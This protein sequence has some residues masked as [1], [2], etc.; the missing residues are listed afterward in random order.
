MTKPASAEE[1]LEPR[2]WWGGRVTAVQVAWT[3]VAVALLA[4][5]GAEIIGERWHAGPWPLDLP[6]VVAATVP[7][8]FFP[9]RPV[10]AVATVAVAAAL[11]ALLFTTPQ[12]LAVMF[13]SLFAAGAAAR[14]APRRALAPLLALIS[15]MI[16]VAALRDPTE[17]SPYN[18][19]F[20]FGI[21]ATAAASG[22]VVRA[23]H[24]AVLQAVE[25]AVRE[26][27]EHELGVER[28]LVEERSRIA[29][30]LHDVVAHAVSL[31]VIQAA[32]GRA[33][34]A[35]DPERAARVFDTIEVSG[36]SALGD[37]R[38]LLGVLQTGDSAEAQPPGLTAVEDLV[39]ATT[40]AGLSCRV[41]WAGD[42]EDVPDG[43]DVAAFRVVQESITNA[44]KHGARAGLD[45]TITRSDA[46][47][48]VD[49]LDRAGGT[50]QTSSI[51]GSGHGL[52]GMRERVAMY[53]GTLAA[54]PTQGGW[55]V[56]AFFP[57]VAGA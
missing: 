25:I 28:A 8:A 15:A 47:I 36:Q 51:V 37:L 39:A 34:G 20:T 35:R 12:S 41:H 42:L 18:Y 5:G 55:R 11:D 45:I 24:A 53:D 17:D 22:F 1:L 56:E 2:R 54:G 14:Y 50:T 23:R 9:T 48:R 26:R 10:P 16:V 31:M 43:I 4:F 3:A 40:A 32:A 19:F 29:R 57:V 13:G 44:L 27:T 7:V 33:V 46:G 21:C 30:D 49:V 38:R 52:Q 6:F